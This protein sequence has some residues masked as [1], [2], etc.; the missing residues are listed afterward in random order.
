MTLALR[1]KLIPLVNLVPKLKS[2]DLKLWALE[3]HILKMAEKGHNHSLV[4]PICH[5]QWNLFVGLVLVDKCMQPWLTFPSPFNDFVDQLN[6]EMSDD[7]QGYKCLL[8]KNCIKILVACFPRSLF[9]CHVVH[10]CRYSWP[11]GLSSRWC[12]DDVSSFYSVLPIQSL[13]LWWSLHPQREGHA[14]WRKYI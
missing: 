8:L 6:S 14:I 2:L 11:V 13:E 7:R 12:F 3:E 1:P 5:V 4:L 10:L 9:L